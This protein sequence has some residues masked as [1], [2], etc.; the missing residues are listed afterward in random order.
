[1][2]PRVRSNFAGEA[3]ALLVELGQTQPPVAVEAIAKHL[4]A[5]IV[6]E[7]LGEDVSG[8][9]LRNDQRT[10][11]GV[12]R[13]HHR[14]RQRFTIAH[15][16]GHLR[17]HPGRP[18]LVDSTVRLN[19]RDDLSSLASDREEIAANAF[20]AALL[21]PEF[22]VRAA[23]KDLAPARI[24]DEVQILDLL[25]RRFDVSTEAISYR[26]INLGIRS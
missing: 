3:E 20:A 12:N 16:L 14:R 8:V 17:L 1:M 5:Q 26:L 23:V 13:S 24:T 19:W 22:M 2:S 11:I 9:L 18:Y 25:A 21:M 15:E 4:G 10:L 7:D 6:L